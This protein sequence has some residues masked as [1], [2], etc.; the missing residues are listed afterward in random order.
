MQPAVLV[1]VVTLLLFVMFEHV[2]VVG[3]EQPAP[4]V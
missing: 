1:Q 3:A 2:P 4:A